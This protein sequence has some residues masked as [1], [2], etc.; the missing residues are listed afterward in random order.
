MLLKIKDK[1]QHNISGFSLIEAMVATAIMGISL[2]GVYSLIGYSQNF[3]YNSSE[4]EE[5]QLMADQ[6]LEIIDSDRANIV[7]YNGNFNSCTA[8]LP[9]DTARSVFYKYKWCQLLTSKFG[10][11]ASTD[12][13]EISVT[14][15]TGGRLVTITLQAKNNRSQIILKKFYDE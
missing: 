1:N 15:V 8:P 7:E 5:L 6:M 13:R 10:T 14:D 12:I 11:P 4:R 3:F 9:E 2:V